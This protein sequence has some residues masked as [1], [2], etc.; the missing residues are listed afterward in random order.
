M[1]NPV[2]HVPAPTVDIKEAGWYFADECE[3]PNGPFPTAKDAWA[4]L[5]QYVRD[6]LGPDPMPPLKL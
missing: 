2:F 5:R 6:L 1:M 4:A 3:Q